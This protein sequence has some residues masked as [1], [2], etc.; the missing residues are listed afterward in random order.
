M[1]KVHSDAHSVSIHYKG[2]CV[3]YW[4]RLEWEED[5]G[6]VPQIVEAI[7][8]AYEEPRKLLKFIKRAKPS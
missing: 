3:L 2:K 1:F 5:A 8:R 7:R 4:D 6:L